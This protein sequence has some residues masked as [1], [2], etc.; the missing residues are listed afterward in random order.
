MKGYTVDIEL[1]LR[2]CEA[3]YDAKDQKGWTLL[4][5]AANGQDD[6]E[7]QFLNI[8]AVDVNVQDFVISSVAAIMGY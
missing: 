8:N 6:F 7:Q 2:T 4:R 5:A 1:R 3:A